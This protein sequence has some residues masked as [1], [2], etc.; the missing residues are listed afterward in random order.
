MLAK[1]LL[2]GAALSP[3]LLAQAGAPAGLRCEYLTDPLGVDVRQPRLSWV[4]EHSARGER[5]SAYQVLV[6]LHSE[7]TAGDV[8]DSGKV[9][10]AEPVQVA[11]GGKA[12]VSGQTYY[13]RVRFWDSQDRASPYSEV[14]RFETGLFDAGDWKGRWIGG[15]NQMRREFT[16]PERP[17]RARAYVAGLGYYELR[18]NGHKVGDHVLDPAWTTYD[19]RVLY[20]V[21]DVTE[22]L[23]KGPNAVGVMLGNGWFKSRAL[24]MQIHAELEDGRSIDVVTDGSWK[25]IA[26]PIREDSIYNGEVYDARLETPGWDRPGFDDAHWKAAELID[27]PHGVLSA[28]MMPPI[29]VTDT[30]VPVR[31]TTPRPGV[32]IY[33][34]GQNISG[35]M[36]LR[37]RGPRGTRVEL[38]HAELLYDDGTLNVENLRSAK[39]TDVYFLR[40]D[41]REEVYQPRFTYHG[42][43]YVELTGYPGAP[44]FDT[45]R[46]KV[47]HSAVRPTGGFTSSKQILNLIQKNIVWGIQDNLHSIPTDC[48]QRDE[49]QGWMADAHLYSETA[50]LN[51]DM[52]AFYTNFLRDIHDVQA[53]DGTITDT[54]PHIWGSRPADPAWGLAYPLI[55]WYMYEYYGDR[56][57]LEE[58]YA[59]VKAWTDYLRTRSKE[60]ILD[61]SYYGDWVPIEKTPGS[62]VSTFCYYWSADL[63]SRMALILGKSGDAASYR[64]LAGTIKD[65]FNAR[66]WNTATDKYGNGTQTS[67]ILPL[68]A[69]MVPQERRG[70]V[71]GALRDDL[72]YTRDTHLTTGILGTKYLFPLL[73]ETGNSDLAYELATQTTYPSWGYMVANGAT[74]LWELWQNKTGPSMNSHNH[75]MFGSL[76]AWFYNALAG[77][78][79]DIS[80][81]GFEHIVI[82]PQVVRDLKWAS[83]SL[84][85]IRG[86]VASSWTRTDTGLR[87]DVVIPTGSDA[88][89]RLPELGQSPVAVEESGRVIWKDGKYQS[90]ASGI[91]GAKAENGTIAVQI[92]SGD[93]SFELRALPPE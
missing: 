80:K 56:R 43:R 30:I 46:A 72:V 89:V 11:Y 52:P 27:G 21:Y 2:L 86:R 40:G 36:E 7:V 83:G 60:G 62:L 61:Y 3:L 71:F 67:Q 87:L 77:I 13:W 47:V 37:V 32:Y 25:A 20:T 70:E 68:F 76:G 16:L 4:L 92:G 51:F 53:A 59:G 6:S 48:N 15:A 75:P 17:L 12:L 79:P 57:I 50:M 33:D 34:L 74:T 58:H 14:A 24:R 28:Q 82:A 84:D 18:I 5:Q 19:K 69:G 73:T 90:G 10:G 9:T 22:R 81:P 63:V 23:R 26:G 38:R 42:F 65:A 35:V 45:L 49:R 91:T 85:T 29:R 54:V 88:E 1:W 93:Y 41:G 39:A 55:T 44:K 8:W 78:N 31:M 66:F 64:N